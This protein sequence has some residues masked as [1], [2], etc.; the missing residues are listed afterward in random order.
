M[1]SRHAILYDVARWRRWRTW[2]LFPATVAFLVSVLTP[3]LRS[4]SSGSTSVYSVTAA[5]LYA[6]AASLWTRRHFA[7]LAVEGDELLVRVVGSRLRIPLAEIRSARL[8]RLES[9]FTGP[10]RRLLPRPTREWLDREAVVIR[11]DSDARTLV[12]LTRMVGPR[13]VDG[14]D[15]VVPVE[16]PRQLLDAI[17]RARPQTVVGSR[18]RRRR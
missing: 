17:H 12:R 10:R 3:L 11:L 1:P 9:R 16:T 6:L 18:R 7:Y 8:A 2:L 5:F 13:C 14:R 4:G 15:L